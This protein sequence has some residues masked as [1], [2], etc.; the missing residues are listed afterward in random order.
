M[1]KKKQ[2]Q[3]KTVTPVKIAATENKVL[4]SRMTGLLLDNYIPCFCC[5][6]KIQQDRDGLF[7]ICVDA[8]NIKKSQQVLKRFSKSQSVLTNF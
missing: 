3:K 4:A 6:Y 2:Y 8:R 5:E 7:V 1:S